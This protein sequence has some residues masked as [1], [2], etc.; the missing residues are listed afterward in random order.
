MTSM[1]S[2]KSS[3]RPNDKASSSPPGS[4]AAGGEPDPLTEALQGQPSAEKAK[5]QATKKAKAAAKRSV[6]ER[7]RNFDLDQ[8]LTREAVDFDLIS[9]LTH[10][11]AVSTSQM[12]RAKLFE[13]TGN[14]SYSTSKYFRQV[15]LVAQRLKYD[16]SRACE[17]VADT[18]KI[19]SVQSLLLH[20][21]TSLSSGEPEEQ[22]LLRESEL[23]RQTYGKQYERHVETL[24]KWSDAYVA[25]MVSATLIVVISLVSM[26]IYP[27]SPLSII[28]LAGLMVCI[29]FVGGW[30]IFTVAPLEVKTNSLKPRSREQERLG[31]LAKI[32]L[33]GAALA[34]AGAGYL[35]GLGPALV[36]VGVVIAPVGVM[37]MIDD[38]RIDAKDR[39]ISTFIRAL[40]G[41]MGAASITA[42]DA[43]S[44]INRRAL[45]SMEPGVRR[46]YIRLKN[47]VSSDLSW[48]RLA[49]ESGSE[50]VTRCVRIFW[51]GI[52]VGGDPEKVS[53][54]ASEFALKIY[55]LRQDRKLVSTT[56]S[57]VAIP[58]HAVLM[59]I[60]FFITEVV[61]VFGDQ[62]NS[63]QQQSLEGGVAAEAGVSDA[64]L[65]AS[66]A[67]G[68]LPVFVGSVALMLTAANSFAP[69][70]AGGGHKLKLCLYAAIMMIISGVSMMLVPA[71]VQAVFT[72]VS[73]IP[74]A[75][76]SPAPTN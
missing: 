61:V 35:L 73:E 26:M 11:S 75:A 68:F 22:F 8:L 59:G 21:A 29:T 33:P 56:F 14:L 72:S 58:L 27:F 18:I 6:G 67:L 50:L 2:T 70:A 1:I 31:Q 64:L 69:Y 49:S 39:D 51:D 43:L 42:T 57:F 48:M 41:V 20:F 54:L 65:F 34:G 40:G 44:R 52:R 15:H 66:P 55:L 74:S 36:I 16:Y 38:W 12:D 3:P 28:G 45:G 24:Q 60:L 9:Q 30:L 23:M 4:G 13:G 10:M 19:E 53:L 5:E 47:G 37:A 25:L 76:G 62:L 17:V 63:V 46:L 71:L 7:L 32:L